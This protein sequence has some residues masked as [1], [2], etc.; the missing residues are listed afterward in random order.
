MLIARRGKIYIL[1]MLLIIIS[2]FFLEMLS[3]LSNVKYAGFYA[4][5]APIIFTHAHACFSE[6]SQSAYHSIPQEF[7]GCS[8]DIGYISRGNAYGN[9]SVYHET[10]KDHRKE[11]RRCVSH[12][13]YGSKYKDG[14]RFI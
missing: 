8:I 6:V 5:K 7:C 1:L 12:Y 4:L 13:L 11:I 2:L 3:A 10:P 9:R 14:G